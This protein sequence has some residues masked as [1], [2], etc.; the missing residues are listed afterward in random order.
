MEAVISPLPDDVEALKALVVTMARK[1][2]E[3]EQHAA[4]VAAELANA[5]ARESAIEALIACQ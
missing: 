3:A 5:L 2:D 4:T 1:A